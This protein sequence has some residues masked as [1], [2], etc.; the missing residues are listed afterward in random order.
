VERTVSN[1]VVVHEAASNDPSLNWFVIA[2]NAQH[3]DISGRLAA[4]SVN[5]RCLF[6]SPQGSLLSKKTPYLIELRSPLQSDQPWSWLIREST[7][8]PCISVIAASRNFE[9]LYGQLVQHTQV[10]LPDEDTMFFAFWD[11][12]ILGTL[13][14]QSDDYSL[15]VSGPVL[16]LEQR[17]K[18]TNGIG[19]WW[20]WDRSGAMH[21]ISVGTSDAQ[22]NTGFLKLSQQ[23]VDELVEASV[24]DHVLHYI[25]LNQAH[26]IRDVHVGERYSLVRT[27]LI[28]AREI[29]LASMRDLVDFVC[30]VLIYKSEVHKN[31]LILELLERVKRREL[32]FRRAIEELP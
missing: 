1:L 29:G 31:K 24:P 16:N 4:A 9:S 13:M 19:F 32:S 15:H 27:A 11:A 25:N 6:D 12:A 22:N 17:A 3:Q 30:V 28:R 21:S 7:Q 26:L 10:V 18:L 2:D 14:G 5:L 20:Y 8:T 23:Q